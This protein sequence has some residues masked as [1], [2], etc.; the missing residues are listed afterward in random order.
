MK[1]TSR[2]STYFSDPSELPCTSQNNDENI[3]QDAVDNIENLYPTK[4]LPGRHSRKLTHKISRFFNL[5][6]PNETFSPCSV[7]LLPLNM[8]CCPNECYSL[9]THMVYV[10]NDTTFRKGITLV[11]EFAPG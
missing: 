5:P 2:I 7:I 6:K 1:N 4:S 10:I 3:S 11:N 8:P 9:N